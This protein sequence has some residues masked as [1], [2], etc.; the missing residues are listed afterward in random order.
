[1]I[2]CLSRRICGPIGS[3]VSSRLSI[4]SPTSRYLT[5]SSHTKSYAVGR[6]E[7]GVTMEESMATPSITYT[8]GVDIGGTFTD[9]AILRDDGLIVTGKAPSTPQDLSL[10]FF[11]AVA[12]GARVLGLTVER[13]LET[14][15]RIS[16]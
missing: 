3:F 16:H 8:V 2:M 5:G 9:C 7:I 10:G 15:T 12:D 14:T 11:D 1:M 13:L 6:R 4:R